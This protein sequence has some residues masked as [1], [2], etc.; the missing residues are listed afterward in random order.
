M[1]DDWEWNELIKPYLA[2]RLAVTGGIIN[3]LKIELSAN[4][5]SLNPQVMPNIPVDV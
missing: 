5:G 2:S 3:R 1:A 4:W